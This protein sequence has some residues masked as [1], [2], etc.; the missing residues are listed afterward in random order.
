MGYS[1]ARKLGRRKVEAAAAQL[2]TL[3][4]RLHL[5]E[6]IVSKL[7]ERENLSLAIG[8]DGSFALVPTPP[9]TDEDATPELEMT[10]LEEAPSEGNA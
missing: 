3:G 4:Q 7:L 6:N 10:V 9:P 1:T 5:M 8:K 2:G